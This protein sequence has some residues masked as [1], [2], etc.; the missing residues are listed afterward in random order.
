MSTGLVYDPRFLDHHTGAAHPER[1]QRLQAILQ[2][3]HRDGLWERL[4]HL[5]ATPA[6]S[7]WVLAVHDAG[8]LGR[9]RSACR[10]GS[11]FIDVA[12]S[13]IC[14]DS[15]EVALLA[16]GGALAAVDAVMQGRVDNA[17]CALRPP[18]HHAERD[19]SMGFCL[20]NNVA[21]AAEY[22]L[23]RYG[24]KRVAIVDFDVHHGNGTQHIFEDRAQVL[25]I[26]LHEHPSFLYPG[27]GFA[28][29]RGRGPGKGYTLNQP[30]EPGAGDDV[31][32]ALFELRVVP[33]IDAFQPQFI[34]LSAG[35]DAGEHDPLAHL[36]LTAAGFDR[37]TRR[38]MQ[39]AAHHCD[40]N[41]I[42]CLEGGYDLRALAECVAG[43]IGCLLA[44]P[45]Q[46]P[47]MAI[48]AGL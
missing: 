17:F 15:Y 23:Q 22:L 46:D 5:P 14:A 31:Y 13:A 8:Y 36:M 2:R 32:Q 24:L 25:F 9:I 6:P 29:E 21:I 35:F 30:I 20:L 44:E 43:H 3:L 12:D 38:L 10:R 48:K 33:A 27:T 28:W 7:Q 1:P 11:R 37:L 47:L 39:L 42:S 16:A 41:L 4:V 40:G 45:G 34:L 26:S 19:A 18:G